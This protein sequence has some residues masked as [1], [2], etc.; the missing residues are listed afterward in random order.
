MSTLLVNRM[1]NL[2]QK[3]AKKGGGQS[4]A[5]TSLIPDSMASKMLHPTMWTNNPYTGLMLAGGGLGAGLGLL[6]SDD[7][8]NKALRSLAGAG[9]GLAGTSALNNMGA[10]DDAVSSAI[11]T[12]GGKVQATAA[13]QTKT[14]GQEAKT[15][16]ADGGSSKKQDGGDGQKSTKVQKQLKPTEFLHANQGNMSPRMAADVARM[17]GIQSAQSGYEAALAQQLAAQQQIEAGRQAMRAGRAANA[18]MAALRGK[19]GPKA[20]VGFWRSLPLM[21]PGIR[22][23]F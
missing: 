12:R 22:R 14:E 1:S 15:D 8:D 13:G 17:R 10:F 4:G 11:K 21:L 9:L 2:I 23:L 6:S 19:L 7:D 18:E 5:Y 16:S 3:Q 20:G